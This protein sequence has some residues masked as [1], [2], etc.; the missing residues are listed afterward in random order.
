M[1]KTWR[2]VRSIS[3]PDDYIPES[4]QRLLENSY[5]DKQQEPDSNGVWP[6]QSS[7][8]LYRV[9]AEETGTSIDITPHL[10]AELAVQHAATAKMGK[11][12][13]FLLDVTDHLQ[14]RVCTQIDSDS[15]FS[16]LRA[17][18][19]S[20]KFES[21][22][23]LRSWLAN[24]CHNSPL[25]HEVDID[26]AEQYVKE[27]TEQLSLPAEWVKAQAHLSTKF[28]PLSA[29]RQQGNFGFWIRGGLLVKKTS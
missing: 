2:L 22:Q 5:S 26:K 6:L 14:G 3:N 9:S 10:A 19:H 13:M 29:K 23:D 20:L 25:C 11:P 8:S 27:V 24:L 21:D 18:H 1:A 16:D 4:I 17:A 12:N 7:V 15:P 28:D